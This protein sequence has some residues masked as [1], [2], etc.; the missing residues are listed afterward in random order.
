MVSVVDDVTV[1]PFKLAP[2][3]FEFDR[4][5]PSRFWF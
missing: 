5:T 3:R 1:A 2:L 4:F